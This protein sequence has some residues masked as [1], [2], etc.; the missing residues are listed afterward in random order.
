MNRTKKKLTNTKTPFRTMCIFWDEHH[1]GP[2]LDAK[3]LEIVNKVINKIDYI[4]KTKNRTKKIICAKNNCQINPNLP[5][6][7]SHFWP[8]NIFFCSRMGS[9]ALWRPIT[10][11]LIIWNMIFLPIQHIP[12]FYVKMATFEGSFFVTGQ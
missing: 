1:F 4:S 2:I 11:E 6:K 7:F 9:L 8:K 10:Q 5:Y 3:H 12:I